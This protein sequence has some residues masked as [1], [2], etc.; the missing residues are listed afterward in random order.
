MM[1]LGFL[2]QHFQRNLAMTRNW[3]SWCVGS[4][5]LLAVTVGRSAEDKT[6]PSA[7]K[8]DFVKDVQPIFEVVHPTDCVVSQIS[9]P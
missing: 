2:Q 5:M 4:A 9:P 3:Q 8:L 1:L 6:Q 7:K